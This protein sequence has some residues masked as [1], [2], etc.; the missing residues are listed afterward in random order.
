MTTTIKDRSID[1]TDTGAISLLTRLLEHYSPSREET[2]VASLLVETMTH[3]G[4]E[5]HLDSAGNAI[6]ELGSGD[7]TVLLLGHM[8]TVAG[9]IPVRR[10]GDRLYG[11]G[12][13]DAK[14]PLAT[15]V[16]ATARAGP[17]PG[18][19]VVVAGAVEEE[20][21]TSKGAYHLLRGPRPD[22]VIIGEPGGW[23]R[24][25]LG[26]RGRLLV[27]YDVTCPMSH[28]A[29]P[30]QSAAE[31]AA[32]FWRDTEALGVKYNETVKGIFGTLD[33]SLRRFNTAEMDFAQNAELTIGLRIPPGIDIGALQQ[34]IRG[35]AA[36]GTVSFRGAEE[37]FRAPKNSPLT[38][39]FLLAIRAQGGKPSFVLKTGTSDMNVVGPRWQCPIVAYGPGDSSLD[40]TPGEH[41]EISE[42]LRGIA[43][44][45]DALGRLAEEIGASESPVMP[46]T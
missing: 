11:R 19:R 22:Y 38:R 21:A 25:T 18:L 7:R 29:G 31:V 27:D 12:A 9:Y 5:A 14:G 37:P 3:L 13:V 10:E 41:I 2:G 15:F 6:G 46:G 39:A 4:F 32:N 34:Q 43:V 28:T 1:K 35:I 24:I 33:P 40:H 23:S 30:C 36:T 16:M 44:L 45:A 26:Y 20:A 17:L 42:Y 8:D